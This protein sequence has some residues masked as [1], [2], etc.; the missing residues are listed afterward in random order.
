M[1]RSLLVGFMLVSTV[2]CG[3]AI[4]PPVGEIVRTFAPVGSYGGHWGIDFATEYGSTVR[5]A[6]DGLVTFAGAVNGVRTVT[7][8][9][10]GALR[11]SYSYLAS[12]GV[13][14][15]DQ[16]HAGDGLGESGTDHGVDAVHFSARI[17]QRYIDPAL[18]PSCD[19][20][21]LRLAPLDP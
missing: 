20:G 11:T 8:L 19:A 17:G 10:G 18:A 14:K 12:I 9:H 2:P 15:G 21:A 7:I 5:A 4:T 16:V 13:E 1:L 6:G 3:A